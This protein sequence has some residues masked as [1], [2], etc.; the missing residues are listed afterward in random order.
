[1]KHRIFG[2][3]AVGC[4]LA[5]GGP[6][7]TAQD[8]PP[9]AEA[10]VEPVADPVVAVVDGREFRLSDVFESARSLPP[11]Y[12]QQIG[13]LLPLLIDR[14]VDFHLL[15]AEA[16]RRNLQDDAAVQAD[17]AR[18]E[19]QVVRQTLLNRYLD[20]AI[21]DASIQA[22]YEQFAAQHPPQ[23]EVRARH[24]LVKSEEEAKAVIDKLGQG[25]DFVELAKTD[26]IEPGA[27]ER[28]GDVGYFL[29]DGMLPEFSAAAFALAV[30]EVSKAPVQ[31][32]Y[33]W[34]VIRVEDRRDVPPPTLEAA[35]EEIVN[36]M[37]R[38]KIQTFLAELR[39]AAEIEKFNPDGSPIAADTSAEGAAP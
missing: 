32:Q 26:S 28:G 34:H 8:Q 20:E 13:E 37:S 1:M 31:S 30:G 19:D 18:Y 22:R 38:E 12:Q 23:V 3:A 29:A 39:A 35:R 25:A 11:Q 6:A 24:I 36:E 27:A 15:T 9:A 17:V 5:L 2:A 14:L 10:P 33:G 4:L 21:D 7:A 16:R